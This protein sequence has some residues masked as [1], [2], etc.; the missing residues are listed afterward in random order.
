MTTASPLPELEQLA[1]AA[2]TA[3]GFRVVGLHLLSH[4][5]PMTLQVMVQRADGSDV[6]LDDCAALSAPLGD[7]IEASGLLTGAYVLE[8]SSP[9]IGE[10]LH[11]DRDFRSFRGFPVAVLHRDAKGVEQRSEGLLLER[12]EVAVHLNL[13]GRPKRIN[14]CDVISVNLITPSSD[15]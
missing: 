11:S 5:L 9:G 15:N 2:A 3:S 8:I 10:V 1:A 12:D 14:R 6:S 4:R 7:A 13:R